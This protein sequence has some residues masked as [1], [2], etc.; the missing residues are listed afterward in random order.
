MY[1]DIVKQIGNI[2]Y[3]YSSRQVRELWGW[4]KTTYMYWRRV[5][6]WEQVVLCHLALHRRDEV[7]E[8]Y[9]QKHCY[10]AEVAWDRLGFSIPRRFINYERY[11][12]AQEKIA[13]I[14]AYDIDL[15]MW[16]PLCMFDQHDPKILSSWAEGGILSQ[17]RFKEAYGRK[18]LYVPDVDREWRQ[19]KERNNL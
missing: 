17:V 18:F 11:L 4:S 2:R 14:P 12:A 16:R 19:Y 5:S 9:I 13:S 8:A 7:N 1:E 6:K 3:W 15:D 10:Q